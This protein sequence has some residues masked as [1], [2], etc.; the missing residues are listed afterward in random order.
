MQD[1]DGS[2]NVFLFVGTLEPAD[3]ECCDF[4]TIIRCELFCRERSEI[5]TVARCG[6]GVFANAEMQ[7]TYKQNEYNK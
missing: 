2:V 7:I 6:S 4:E 5:N 3:V 1:I